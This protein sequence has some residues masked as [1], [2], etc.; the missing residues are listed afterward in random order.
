VTKTDCGRD[1]PTWGF[2]GIR[3]GSR[4]K[5]TAVPKTRG[6]ARKR[7]SLRGDGVGA[8]LFGA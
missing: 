3:N 5:S 4:D 7:G 2:D 8:L 6:D 1:N